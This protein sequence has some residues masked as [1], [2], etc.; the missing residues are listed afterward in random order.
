MHMRYG[1]II[2]KDELGD[3]WEK[4]FIIFVETG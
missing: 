4:V 1:K 2:T 3:M